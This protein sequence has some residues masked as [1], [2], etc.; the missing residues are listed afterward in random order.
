ML[1]DLIKVKESMLR[2]K[3]SLDDY[4]M[5]APELLE[6]T[7]HDLIHPGEAYIETVQISRFLSE[8]TKTVSIILYGAAIAYT[9]QQLTAEAIVDTQDFVCNGNTLWVGSRCSYWSVAATFMAQHL[10]HHIT[11]T[12]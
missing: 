4:L 2:K 11:P 3:T 10:Y 7:L 12:T 9:Q 6:F 1:A 8:P 5:G